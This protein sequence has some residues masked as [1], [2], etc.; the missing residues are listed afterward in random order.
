[1]NKQVNLSQK[2]RHKYRT[3][4]N[5]FLNIP[6]KAVRTKDNIIYLT[7]ENYKNLSNKRN[8]E[9]I[10]WDENFI[11][12]IQTYDIDFIYDPNVNLW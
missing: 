10:Q 1:M 5:E 12:L 11:W 6:R 4:R 2:P 9:F 7:L 3:S 8:I